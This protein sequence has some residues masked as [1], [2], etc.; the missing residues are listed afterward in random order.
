MAAE[1]DKASLEPTSE[2]LQSISPAQRA[3]IVIAMMGEERAKPIIEQL[4]DAALAKI[5]SGLDALALLGK[6]ELTEIVIDFLAH[7]RNTSGGFV[8][9]KVATKDL[10]SN[11]MNFRILPETDDTSE[12]N[13]VPVGAEEDDVQ[14]VHDAQEVWTELENCPIEKVAEYLGTLTPNLV[15]IVINELPV[16]MSS[17]IFNH[18]DDEKLKAIMGHMVEAKDIDPGVKSVIGRMIRMEFINV[19]QSGS[20]ESNAHLSGIGEL[21]SLIPSG[22]RNKL[23]QFLESDHSSKLDDIQGALCTIESL[24]DVLP[25]TA[26]PI[27]F[28]DMEM[29]DITALLSTL[30]GPSASVSEFLLGN[31]SSRLA[32]QIKDKLS[33]QATPSDEDAEEIQRSFLMKVMAFNRN[34]DSAA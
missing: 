12:T 33:G 32:D 28:R 21:L 7:L 16:T 31:I 24:P 2:R 25:R 8:S 3:A 13:V 18:L 27:V 14:N 26:V 5:T 9:G 30:H 29:D 4:D 17:E 23:V 6:S 11:V 1:K 10:V 34:S 19:Q 22:K 15:A 20:E